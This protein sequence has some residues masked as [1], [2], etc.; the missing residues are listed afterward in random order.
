MFMLNVTSAEAQN[1]F[2]QLLGSA[3]REPVAITQRGRPAAY[4]ISP[5]EINE[6][7]EAPRARGEERI[8]QQRH[9]ADAC[10]DGWNAVQAQ[11]GSF[12]DE[13]SPL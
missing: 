3:Q 6:L 13:H 1:R 7:Q 2:G 9:W 11:W 12:A 5:Q 4:I 10:A 8:Q